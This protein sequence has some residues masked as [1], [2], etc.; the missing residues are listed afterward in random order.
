MGQP[1][2]SSEVM[3]RYSVTTMALLSNDADINKRVD[4]ANFIFHTYDIPVVRVCFADL[5]ERGM[6]PAN[7][8]EHRV[9]TIQKTFKNLNNTTPICVI[10][11]DPVTRIEVELL[12]SKG[13]RIIAV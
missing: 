11:V 4:Y 12:V 7:T 1:L 5:A 6:I 2:P 8:V 13:A 3:R 9:K 10:F